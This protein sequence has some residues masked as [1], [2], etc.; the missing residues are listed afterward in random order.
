[1]TNLDCLRCDL[2]IVRRNVVAGEGNLHSK[3]MFIGEAP[4]YKEDRTGRPFVGKAGTLLTTY[5]EAHGFDRRRNSYLTNTIKC[6]PPMNRIPTDVETL[7]CMPYLLKEILTI[8]PTIIVSLGATALQTLFGNKGISLTRSRGYLYP[9][10]NAVVYP[11]YHPSYILQSCNYFYY[12][13][14]FKTLSQLYK[15]LINPNHYG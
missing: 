13:Q 15:L 10:H 5:M 14:D 3:L 1:M 8:N 2:C 11:M 4:G 9:L 7:N 12:D 6:R